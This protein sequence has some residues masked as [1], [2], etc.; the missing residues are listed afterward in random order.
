MTVYRLIALGVTTCAAGLSVAACAAGITT[1]SPAASGSPAASRA[2][3]SPTASHPAA[4]P[5]SPSSVDTVSV[6][7]P[8][9]SF[10]IPRTARIVLGA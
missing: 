5:V 3:S 8:V 2:A 4:A 10:P 6:D 1:A 7:A 9:G